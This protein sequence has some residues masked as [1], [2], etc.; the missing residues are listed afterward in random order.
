ME[1]LAECYKQHSDFSL[2]TEST[3]ISELSVG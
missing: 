3:I 2:G 1:I